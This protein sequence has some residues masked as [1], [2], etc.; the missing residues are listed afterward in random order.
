MREKKS[1][2]TENNQLNKGYKSENKLG[3][4]ATFKADT[5]KLGLPDSSIF[6]AYE[7]MEPGTIAKMIEMTA[8]EQEHR[9]NVELIHLRM[10]KIGIRMGRLFAIF[11]V[12]AICY[13]AYA[14]SV[15]NM[16]K[17]AIIFAVVGFVAI[18]ISGCAGK[19]KNNIC[20]PKD[21]VDNSTPVKK[22][23]YERNNNPRAENSEGDSASSSVGASSAPNYKPYYRRR[24]NTKS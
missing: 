16:Q 9:H 8:K 7:D 22:Q 18:A 13:T 10:Q 14:M 1:F 23:Y 15:H 4:K 2:F 24:K 6:A 11:S 3:T 5:S 19:C 12:M 21:K 20:E 17:E